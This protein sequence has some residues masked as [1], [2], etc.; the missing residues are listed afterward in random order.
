MEPTFA[1]IDLEKYIAEKKKNTRIFAHFCSYTPEEIIHAA[2]ILPVRIFGTGTVEK[3]NTHLQSYCCSYAKR[4]LEQGMTSQYDGAVFVHSCDTMQRLSDIWFKT[5]PE[6][7]HETVVFPVAMDKGSTYLEKELERF[8]MN[9]EEYAGKISDNSI[10][11]SIKIYNENRKLLKRLYEKRKEGHIPA[12]AIDHIMR[13]AMTM[14]REE[15]TKLLK[16]F[17]EEVELQ[18]NSN[19]HLLIAGSIILDPEILNIIEEY[20][21]IR[22]DDLCTGSRYLEPVTEI[23]LKGIAR[24]YHTMWCPCRAAAP[25]GDYIAEKCKEYSIDGV[26]LLLQKFC[27]PHFFEAVHTKNQLKEHG[28]PC[29]LFELQDQPLEQLRTRIQAFCEMLEG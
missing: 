28:Y 11:E 9:L 27:E 20:G 23:S 4:A 19:P 7:F 12:I 3:A 8:K 29:V 22:Y 10:K 26:V 25:R 18:E 13:A 14:L 15:H 17:L 24:R 1:T 5:I 6:R 2:G 21:S 16:Q